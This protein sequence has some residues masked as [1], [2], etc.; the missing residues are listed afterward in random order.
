VSHGRS[1]N[2]LFGSWASPITSDPIV[3]Q[4][5]GLHDVLLDGVETYWVEG[6]PWE[7]GRYVLVRLAAVGATTDVNPPP[8]NAWTRVHE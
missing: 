4:S 6:H 3:A 2:R 7:S 5:L 8:I 1:A